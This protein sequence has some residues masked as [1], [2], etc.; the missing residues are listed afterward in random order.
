MIY[1]ESS[2]RTSTV[3]AT[4]MNGVA[5]YRRTHTVRGEEDLSAR[6]ACWT[7]HPHPFRLLADG[8]AKASRLQERNTGMHSS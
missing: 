4:P 2:A 5:A 7:S 1:C 8:T 6:A 3:A